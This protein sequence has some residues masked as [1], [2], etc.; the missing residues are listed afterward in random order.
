MIHIA[1]VIH[2]DLS[3]NIAPDGTRESISS[4]RK[5]YGRFVPFFPI[6]KDLNV[7][8]RGSIKCI[9][10][11]RYKKYPDLKPQNTR[12]NKKKKTGRWNLVT[13]STGGEAF[14]KNAFFT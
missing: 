11:N 10:I 5:K 14:R 2:N 6:K 13:F 3:L 4:C 7:Q 9:V 1:K 8:H 12:Y